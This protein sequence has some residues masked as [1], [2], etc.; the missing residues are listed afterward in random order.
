MDEMTEIKRLWAETPAASDGEL[1]RSRALL[2]QAAAPRPAVRR[3]P[4]RLLRRTALAGGLAAAMTGAVIAGQV[5][6]SG[7]AGSGGVGRLL[8]APPASA[9]E[10][11]ER[12]ARAAVNQR[13]RPAQHQY[14]HT[15]LQVTEVRHLRSRDGRAETR[16]YLVGREER[17]VPAD[18]GRPWLLRRHAATETPAPGGTSDAGR[19]DTPAGRTDTPVGRPDAT[20]GRADATAGRADTP[21]DTVYS[22]SCP[23]GSSGPGPAGWPAEPDAL[24]EVVEKEAA[25]AT[26]VPERL[27]LWGAVGTALRESVSRPELTASLYRIA[28]EVEGITLVPDAVDVAGRRGVGVA[29]DR[30]DGRREMLVFEKGTYRYLGEQVEATRDVTTTLRPPRGP[31]RGKTITWVTPKGTVTGSAVIEAEVADALPPVGAKASKITLPC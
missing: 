10:V 22:T 25:K 16:T 5:W 13:L 26:A 31:D 15:A 4:A 6:L 19:M 2:L 20:A 30:G 17:W 24:R 21:E 9:Q 7:P 8:G 29:M 14:V 23:P 28:A 11:L 12:A 3:S 27:R 18:G 1:G